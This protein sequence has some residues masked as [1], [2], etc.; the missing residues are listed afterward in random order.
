MKCITVMIDLD[1]NHQLVPE[2]F[3]GTE[4]T[5]SPWNSQS[6]RRYP[7]TVLVTLSFGLMHSSDKDQAIRYESV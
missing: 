3:T 6:K 7:S 4:M 2:R 5:F 1:L